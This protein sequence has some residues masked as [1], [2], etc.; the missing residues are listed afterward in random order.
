MAAHFNRKGITPI[1]AA[2]LLVMIGVAAA[3]G[4]FFW[5]T[6]I[7]SQGQGNVEGSENTLLENVAT[8]V[9]MPSATFDLTNNKL[10]LAIQNC[11]SNKFIVGD[12]DDKFIITPE[13]CSFVPTCSMV[14]STVCP[15]TLLPGALGRMDFNTGLITCE[16]SANGT[17]AST[18]AN[19]Q[20]VSHQLIISIDKKT[21]AARGFVPETST[22]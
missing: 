20:G 7:Q 5:L 11:G 9:D 12:G 16:G 10:R 4:M 1:I 18:M 21:T 6:K 22:A 14:T 19:Q 15:M 2:I 3:G 17:L 13:T 8:C